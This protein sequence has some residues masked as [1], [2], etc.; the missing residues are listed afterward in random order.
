MNRVLSK[1]YSEV[2]LNAYRE[3]SRDVKILCLQRF[4]RL[5]A[6]GMSTL[7]LVFYLVD[8]GVTVLQ[9]GLFMTLTLAGDVVLS[10]VLTVIADQVGRRR[11]LAFGSLLMAASG[12]IFALS[13]NYWTLLFA[14]VFGVISPSGNEVGPFKAIEESIISQLTASDERSSMLAWYTLHGTA[15]VALG[16]ISCGWTVRILQSHYGWKPVATYRLIYVA[17]AG[18]GVLKLLLCIMLSPTCEVEVIAERIESDEQR[19]LLAADLATPHETSLIH[20]ASQK[21]KGNGILPTYSPETRLLLLKLGFIFSLDSLGSGLAPPSWLIY[22]FHTKFGFRESKLGNLFFVTNILS[23]ASNL[24]SSSLARRIGLIKT[25]IFTNAP[26]AVA[27]AFIPI[28]SNGVIAA[29][30]LIFRS[31]IKSMDQAPGQAFLAAAVLPSERTS[32]M[33]IMNVVKTTSQA[34]GPVVTGKLAG[35]GK[36]WVAFVL[37]GSLKLLYDV[38]LLGMFLGY[39]TVE[40]RAEAK[41]V[42]D[43]P[44]TQ[45]EDAE[46]IR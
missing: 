31:S 36:F 8:L 14:S 13:S 3:S 16:T 26:A 2:G 4:V 22:F 30:L 38:L 18:F 20:G 28:P 9:T 19:P 7:I 43:A 41:A 10:L 46:A 27:L 1:I 44:Q 40:D 34:V 45:E 11:L 33:G 21:Q 23:S 25:M 35:S 29:I 24:A 42:A 5:V 37:A 6:Y 32:V 39:K 12:V 15:G 17:Y